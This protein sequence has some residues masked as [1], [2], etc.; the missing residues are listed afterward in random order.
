MLLDIGKVTVADKL[1]YIVLECLVYEMLMLGYSI[2][3]KLIP[4]STIDTKGIK[5]FTTY[6]SK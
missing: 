5:K 1:S 2:T 3:V 6:V 4:D